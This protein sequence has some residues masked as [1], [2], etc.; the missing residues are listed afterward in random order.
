MLKFSYIE[1]DELP[2]RVLIDN[3]LHGA[4]QTKSDAVVTA[5]SAGQMFPAE[6]RS[7]KKAIAS[8]IFWN[9]AN[10]NWAELIRILEEGN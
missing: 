4:G 6:M 9:E 1:N 5:L 3:R 2:H 7:D 8:F 10:P